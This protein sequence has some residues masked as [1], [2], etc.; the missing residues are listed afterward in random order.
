M[1]SRYPINSAAP[2]EPQHV[3]TVQEALPLN[4]D[5][6]DT[7]S[8]DFRVIARHQQQDQGLQY[9]LST[10]DY[11]IKNIH[12]PNIIFFKDKIAIPATLVDRIIIWYQEL[13]NHPGVRYTHRTISEHFYTRGMEACVRILIR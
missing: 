1:V 7:C 3:C 11:S 5:D 10:P 2:S 9:N 6:E 4:D 12:G 13:L 8:I